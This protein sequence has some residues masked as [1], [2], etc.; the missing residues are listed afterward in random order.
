M[1]MIIS[2]ERVGSIV[3]VLRDPVMGILMGEVVGR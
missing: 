2:A 3:A 1:S